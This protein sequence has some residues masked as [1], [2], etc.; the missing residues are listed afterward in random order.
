MANTTRRRTGKID[1]LDR[2]TKDEVEQMLLSGVTYREIVEFLRA[3]GITLSRMAVCTYAK[4]FL[5]TT[6]M[7]RIAQENFRMLTDEL[8]KHPTLDTTEA[9][10]QIMSNSILNTLA[11]TQPEDWQKIGVDKLL[12]EANSL[13]KVTA[14]KRS[15]RDPGEAAMQDVNALMFQAMARENPGLY[16]QVRRFLNSKKD[17]IESGTGRG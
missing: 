12:R 17:E 11:N 14:Y 13:V 3:K 2:Q 15:R 16:E 6:Q 10:I 4:K 8:D 5:A 9:I 1:R 7:L